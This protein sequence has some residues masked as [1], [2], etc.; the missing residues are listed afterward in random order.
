[1]KSLKSLPIV[2]FAIVMFSVIACKK[3]G[4]DTNN[5]SRPIEHWV[6][7]SVLDTMPRMITMA[8]ND[9]LWVSYHTASG[10][11][12]K[13]WKGTVYFDG[14]VYTGAHGP[15]PITIGDAYVENKFKQPWF[16]LSSKGD[17]IAINYRYKGHRFVNGHV[18]LMHSI[19]LPSKQSIT[20]NEQVEASQSEGGS[21][22]LERAFTTSLVPQGYSVGL[23]YNLSSIVSESSTDTDGKIVGLK[24][25]DA[26]LDDITYA[27]VDASLILKSN[28]KTKFNTTF[29]SRPTISNRNVAGGVEEEKEA[30]AGGLHPGLKLIAKSDCKSCHNKNLKT[31]GPSY[32]DIAKKYENNAGNISLLSSKVKKGGSGVW[33][34]QVMTAHDDLP[35]E[36]IKEMVTYIMSLDID[37]DSAAGAE[38]SKKQ[39]IILTPASI[40]DEDVLPG[41]V[42]KVYDI[43]ANT[44]KIPIFPGNKKP[45]FAGIMPNFNN[46]SG[47]G[48]RDLTENFGLTAS[49]FFYIEKEGEY[50]F[51]IWSDDG[52]KVYF[53]DKL[54]MDND[55]MHGPAYKD[56]T[57]KC[58]KG[59]YPFRIEFYQGG[60]G[61]YL[62]FDW[63]KP[64][65]KEYEI[66]PAA[67]IFHLVSE[68]ESLSGYS[69]PMSE[70][71]RVP[72]D[73]SP[74]ND[75]HPSFDLA[76]ARPGSFKPKVGGI[77]FK[78][79]GRM[80]VSTWE[81]TGSIWIIEG[82]ET[83]DSTK[84]KHKRIAFGLAEP[85]GVKVVE[86]TIYVMQK[87]EITKL[88]DT[89]GDDIIDEYRTLSYGWRVSPNFH[90]FG[91][92]LVYKDGFFYATLATAIQ[93]GGAST[94]PQIP[95]R[96]KVVKINKVNGETSFIASGLRT[97][98]GIGLGMGG[99][100][101]VADN[102]GDWLPASKIVHVRDGAWFGSRSVDPVGTKDRKEDLPVVWLPQ[103]EIGNS[104]STPLGIE[105]GPWKGQM[106]H[107]EVTNGGVKRVF[108]E[109]I[110]GQLQGCVFR[111]IQGL[112][113][114]I[115][116]IAW[117]P[118]GDLYAGGIGNGGNWGQN[119]K[120]YYGLE[121][122]HYNGKSTFEMLAVRAK[123]NGLEIEYTEPVTYTASDPKLYE[124]KQWYYKPTIDYGGPKLGEQNL[125]VKSATVSADRKKVFLEIP[126]IKANHVVY[127]HLRKHII[128]QPG[129]TIWS[130]EAWYTMNQVPQN[131]LGTV[132][133]DKY[134]FAPNTLSPSEVADGW[135]L[136]F[137]G[138]SLNGWRNYNKQ[139]TGK[140][141]IIQDG[142]IHLNSLKTPTG[143]KTED[144]GDIIT[145]K[146]Y[147]NFDF[148]CEWKINNCGNSG[149]FFNVVEDKKY[150]ATY[151]TGIEM[152]VLD[153]LC[154]AD[155]R[156][157]KHKAGDLYDLKESKYQTVRA[158]G[159]WNEARIR[160]INGKIDFWLNGVNVISAQ[161]GDA[162]WKKMLADSKFKD[163]EG[164]AK[165]MEG[166]IALQDH[167]DK[168]WYRNIKIK[169]IK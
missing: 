43:P 46:L 37:S 91:F 28:D 133:P 109:K 135:K 127:V 84:I 154:H 161:I 108:V 83:G 1:M 97:P 164:F 40:K 67:N 126:G 82:H 51:Q 35:E 111:F 21:P 10:A 54:V 163:W 140:S 34:E 120:Q 121:K 129:Q 106:I 12:Y 15:Q 122:L 132:N 88:V 22:I 138:K 66:V 85:L 124:I 130:T 77:D 7:R 115:N 107:G 141:W 72:G 147:K 155:A 75:V 116:R 105:I 68:N 62:A 50:T 119:G 38:V 60:G 57:V 149:V 128:S 76:T 151:L 20:I 41:A 52:S 33:G 94:N 134:D 14:A 103:D 167:S 32:V 110:N 24:K 159:Q 93:P 47:S 69:L 86:D 55:G 30:P 102:Q 166:H 99:E 53:G 165:T 78:K 18:E 25:S 142:A 162:E 19:E 114:G 145:N 139:T 104:P 17:T 160:Q 27:E 137:D 90:E 144:G 64:G 59:Y 146:K 56:V 112:E 79:D 101:F 58:V 148:S 158:A 168:V 31:I 45:K 152:Q 3:E 48:F 29:L 2:A 63:I 89:N 11:L 87:Q 113:A 16:V 42:T 61:N 156:Y 70:G 153:N 6:F 96:G 95:D 74:L 65:D 73:M 100:I 71:N 92:G 49:G 8:L 157:K 117:G 39:V 125:T 9:K 150:D 169:E 80:I 13:A 5:S 143:W 98:N 118:Q 81:E 44:Q 23:K 26:K 4:S 36:D 123:S 136:L 131:N